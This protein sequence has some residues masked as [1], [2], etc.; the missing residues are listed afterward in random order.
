MYRSVILVF[1]ISG[2]LI[3][4]SSFFQKYDLP[5]SIERGK[6]VYETYCMSCHM[7]EGQGTEIFPPVAK[8]DYLKK[9]VKTLVNIILLG[10]SGEITVNKKKY[11]ALMPPQPY[12]SDEQI[13]DVLN[14]VRNK[15][16]NKV[17]G[18]ITPEQVKALR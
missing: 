14:Y 9:P 5:K 2:F 8:T 4:T 15:M 11:D 7:P 3:L 17:P 1:V 12:L 6:E 18:A 13:A 10:Q 16:G